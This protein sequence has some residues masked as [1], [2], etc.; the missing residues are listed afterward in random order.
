MGGGFSV[1]IG[2]I[3]SLRD[4]VDASNE[5]DQRGEDAAHQVPQVGKE[6]IHRATEAIKALKVQGE[7]RVGQR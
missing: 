2:K 4:V 7:P 6:A 5:R 3:K 1:H